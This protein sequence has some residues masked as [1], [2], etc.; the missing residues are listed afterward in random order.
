MTRLQTCQLDPCHF[1]VRVPHFEMATELYSLGHC[2]ACHDLDMFGMASVR[3]KGSQ[4]ARKRL[5]TADWGAACT[6]RDMEHEP[7]IPE[8]NLPDTRYQ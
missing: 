2:R 7:L 1:W 8:A 3:S 5:S 6:I 4:C